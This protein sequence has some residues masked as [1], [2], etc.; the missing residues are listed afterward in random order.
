LQVLAG[1]ALASRPPR[2]LVSDAAGGPLAR[3]VD[4]AIMATPA[5]QDRAGTPPADER[6]FRVRAAD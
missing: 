3:G 1:L 4:Y 5:A 2:P 6:T